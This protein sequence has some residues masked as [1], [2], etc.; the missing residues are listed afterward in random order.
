MNKI[1]LIGNI[2]KE[3]NLIE[4]KEGKSAITFTV[5][6]TE[7]YKKQNGEETELTTWHNIVGW[8]WIAKKPL[9]KG[10]RVFVS[11]KISNRSYEDKDGNTKYITEIV[12]DFVDIFSKLEKLPELEKTTI[13]TPAEQKFDSGSGELPF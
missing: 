9:Q 1:T 7:K 4:T 11:G 10:Q 3:P 8:G 2:G 5:A 6:T 12:A 13:P